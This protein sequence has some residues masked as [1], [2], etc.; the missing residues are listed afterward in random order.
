MLHTISTFC[1][2]EGDRIFSEKESFLFQLLAA[3]FGI[4]QLGI[5]NL[6][7]NNRFVIPI[8]VAPYQ[9]FDTNRIQVDLAQDLF[10]IL[11]MSCWLFSASETWKLHVCYKNLD[12]KLA[13]NGNSFTLNHEIIVQEQQTWGTYQSISPTIDTKASIEDFLTHSDP[14][15][16]RI[17]FTIK[18]L[19]L[20]ELKKMA[21]DISL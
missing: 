14:S 18:A 17:A 10:L 4:N 2:V 21:E 12:S 3:K 9:C 8:Y 15:I 6:P 11:N 5:R 16:R 20:E 7:L 1:I 19:N 13:A